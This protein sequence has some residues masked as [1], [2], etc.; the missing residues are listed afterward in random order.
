MS[1]R[2]C[3]CWVLTIELFGYMVTASLHARI[4]VKDEKTLWVD[5]LSY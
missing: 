3:E 2:F 5:E 1:P 4:L